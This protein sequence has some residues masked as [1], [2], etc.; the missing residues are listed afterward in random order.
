IPGQGGVTATGSAPAALRIPA[1]RF[2]EDAM[3]AVPLNGIELVQIAT[4][5]GIDAPYAA[6]TVAPGGGPGSFTWCPGDPACVAAGGLRST[7]PPPGAGPRNGRVICR[8]GAHPLRGAMHLGLRRGGE[9]S[10]LFQAAPFQPGH[11]PSRGSGSA[12]RASV[13]GGLGSADAPSKRTIFLPRGFATQPTMPP[14]PFDVIRY[15]GPRV[16]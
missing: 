7:D 16:T 5:I 12:L 11:L 1:H 4:S 9:T 10:F 8:P 14:V 15:P 13:L 2:V 6:A 3:A